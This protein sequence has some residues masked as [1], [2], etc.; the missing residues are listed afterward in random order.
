MQKMWTRKV[1]K[2][3][4]V[5]GL[6]VALV[7]GCASLPQGS[8]SPVIDRIQK[9]GELRVGMAGDYPPLNARDRQ[10]ENFGLEADLASFLAKA[11]GVKLRVVNRPF[12]EL[13]GALETGEVDAVLSGMSMTPERNQRVAFAG[14]Y[15]VSGKCVLSRSET[16]VR[17]R[18]EAELDQS[19]LTLTALEGTTSATMI[20]SAMPSARY[21]PATSYDAAVQSVLDGSADALITDFPVC[22]VQAARRRG[23]GLLIQKEPFTFE[24]IGIALPAND[25]L[26]VNLAQN[27]LVSLERTGLLERL[28]DKWINDASWVSRLP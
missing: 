7:A 10:G 16:L 13:I 20:H 26:F 24:P 22:V 9:S 25:P 2:H 27:Y 19:S 8:R 1:S 3:G 14:P 17:T 21:V 28:K 11:L 12:A 4:A 23:D 5:L 6:V 15:F 18:K